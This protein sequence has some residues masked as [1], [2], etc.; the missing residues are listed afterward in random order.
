MWMRELCCVK[1]LYHTINSTLDTVSRSIVLFFW[2][3]YFLG[4]GANR[5]NKKWCA[6][7]LFI[8]EFLCTFE[9]D[10]LLLLARLK[11]GYIA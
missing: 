4:A 1:G 10:V 8:Y 5:L 7:K 11:K 3:S 6:Q 2:R 9:I